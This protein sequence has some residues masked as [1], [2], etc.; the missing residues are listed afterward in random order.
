MTPDGERNR[1]MGR[2]AW[3]QGRTQGRVPAFLFTLWVADCCWRNH[4]PKC[5]DRGKQKKPQ[6]KPAPSSQNTKK[7]KKKG[8]ANRKLTDNDCGKTPQK[9]TEAWL[10]QQ[11]KPK[12]EPDL[13]ATQVIRV[14]FSL[15]TLWKWRQRANTGLGLSLC[16]A[17]RARTLQCQS[18]PRRKLEFSPPLSSNAV[19]GWY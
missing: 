7:K 10:W 18:R 19:P 3:D 17:G 6:E 5:T 16:W 2:G 13:G 11:Q 12:G 4:W 1:Q 14:C 8:L 15:R 9:I